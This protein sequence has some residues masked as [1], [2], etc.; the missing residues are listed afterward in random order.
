VRQSGD[1]SSS[2]IGDDVPM[3]LRTRR[4]GRLAA[5]FVAVSML[6]L[7]GCGSDDSD[8]PETPGTSMPGTTDAELANPASEYCVAQGGEVEIV[9]GDDGQEGI[10]VLPDGTRIDEWEYFRSATSTVPTSTP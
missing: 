3:Q 2:P 7:A 9:D 8:T 4:T 6:A 10:C 1:A 5:T